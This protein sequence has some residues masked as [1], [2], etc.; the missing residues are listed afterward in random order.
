MNLLRNPGTFRNLI[1]VFGIV[2]AG[3]QLEVP[4][5][6]E[7]EPAVASG[8]RSSHEDASPTRAAEPAEDVKAALGSLPNAELVPW[9]EKTALGLVALSLACVDRPHKQSRRRGYLYESSYALRTDYESALAF[10]GCSDWHSA[11]NSTWTMVKVL[12]EFPESPIAKLIREKLNHHLS[13]KSL[14]GERAFFEERARAGFERPFG[15]AWLLRIS[16]ELQDWEDEDGEKW[17]ENLRPLA[18]LLAERMIEYLDHLAYPIRVGTHAN[19]AYSFLFMLDYAR[20]VGDEKLE[21]AIEIRARDFFFDDEN[22]PVAYEPS[23]SDFLSPCLAEAVI[24]SQFMSQEEW[25]PWLDAFLPPVDSPGFAPLLSAFEFEEYYLPRPEFTPPP[26]ESAEAES[27]SDPES[28]DDS[29][30]NEERRL[31]GAQ[32][33]LIGLAFLRAAALE[34]IANALPEEDPRREAFQGIARLQASKG[35]E[36]MYDADY[37]GTHWIASYAVDMLT[38][39][40]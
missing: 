12:K 38:H 34:R 11:V 31:K 1:S 22:C 5:T 16:A 8:E 30:R 14:Q 17:A 9:D 27:E 40:R 26:R 21:R 32:S 19:T 18:E 33:H 28:D 24:V 6:A 20:A 2:L 15:W 29:D 35:F 39:D 3:C 4:E 25:L 36:S 13:E 23:G 10:Y 7:G 37:V